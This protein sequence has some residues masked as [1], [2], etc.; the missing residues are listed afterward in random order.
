MNLDELSGTVHAYM[1]L[2]S[3]SVSWMQEKEAIVMQTYYLESSASQ[4]PTALRFFTP[5]VL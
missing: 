4:N 5:K 2:V 3:H 1:Q